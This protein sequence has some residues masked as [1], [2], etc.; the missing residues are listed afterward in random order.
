MKPANRLK[1]TMKNLDQIEQIVEYQVCNTP[2]YF[3]YR[4]QLRDL[5][6]TL[7]ELSID[8]KEHQ[9]KFAKRL[10]RSKFFDNLTFWKRIK[11]GIKWIILGRV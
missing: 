1:T 3:K 4:R 2:D 5:R 7:E 11:L 9:I 8:K 10:L 6:N